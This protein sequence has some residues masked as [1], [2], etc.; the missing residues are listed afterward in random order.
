[1]KISKKILSI[2][3]VVML[4]ATIIPLGASAAP[5]EE[6]WVSAWSTS[7]ISASLSDL[8]I[9]DNLGVTLTAVSSRVTVNPTA[10]GSQVRL[11]FSNEF[12]VTPLTISACSIGLTGSS[13]KTVQCK[14]IKDVTF[15]GKVYKVIPAGQVVTSDPIDFNV[16]AGE[17]ITVTT[18]FRGINA[19]RTI[20]LIGGDTYATV[21]NY[22][23]ISSMALGIPLSL[24][25]DSG[26]YEVIPAL[27]GIDV[28]SAD[29][30]ACNCVIFGDSTVANEIP[31]LL[32]AKLQANGI[33]NISVTQQAIK[34]NRLVADGVGVA[35]NV[36]GEAGIDRFDRDVLQ[37][38]GVKYVVVKLGINDIVHPYCESKADK[39]TPVTFDEM[40]AG[41]TELVE[42]AH[43]NGIEIYFAELTPWKGYTRDILGTGAD[44]QWTEEIDAIRLQLNA[45][46]A[47]DDC[48]ADGYIGLPTLADINDIYALAPAFTTDGIHFTT[49]GQQAFV[50]AFPIDIFA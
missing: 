2:A 17:K 36:L 22:T 21:G 34:G 49:A 18:Y 50:D 30:D 27:M 41:Y 29:E 42:M 24:S 23:H 25:A 10:S 11:T 12:G 14:T 6:N 28:L 45:W 1:M 15:D 33:T 46:F 48:P 3:L 4:I 32:E 40:V 16:T 20:G 47:S 35:A 9:L 5:A 19:Q 37:Q 31:R 26:A 44:V 8:G 38:P 39:L 7:P 13:S 43:A